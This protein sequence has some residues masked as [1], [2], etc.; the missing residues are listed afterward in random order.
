MMFVPANDQR[1]DLN[2][3]NKPAFNGHPGDTRP[4]R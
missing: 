3:P 2:T 4:S 1:A